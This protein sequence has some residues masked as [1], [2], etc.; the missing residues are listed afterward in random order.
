MQVGVAVAMAIE[1]GVNTK[2]I[3][4]R[5]SRVGFRY[6]CCSKVLQSDIT[7]TAGSRDNGPL[8]T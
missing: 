6:N 7:L 1:L 2:L 8:V 5:L 4:E 3:G